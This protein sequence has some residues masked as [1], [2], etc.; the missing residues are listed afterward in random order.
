MA[1]RKLKVRDK[2]LKVLRSMSNGKTVV[3]VGAICEALGGEHSLGVTSRAMRE[4]RKQRRDITYMK[5]RGY[6][7]R[8]EYEEE[9][10]GELQSV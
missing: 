2:C 5:R 7:L 3:S 4:L 6:R 9:P 1:I 8:V 10:V